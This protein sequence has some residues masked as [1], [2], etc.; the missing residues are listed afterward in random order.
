LVIS[1]A[2]SAT[3]DSRITTT[4]LD[5]RLRRPPSDH[6]GGG[7]ERRATSDSLVVH[8]RRTLHSSEDLP[9]LSH[10]PFEAVPG[11]RGLARPTAF[12]IIADRLRLLLISRLLRRHGRLFSPRLFVATIRSNIDWQARA[13]PREKNLTPT[14]DASRFTS[15]P[16]TTPTTTS[17][18]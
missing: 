9:L 13:G 11:H 14:L 1:F 7:D 6:D 2:W 3:P 8:I 16:A 17:P 12:I 5:F 4:L 15:L 18:W 10:T